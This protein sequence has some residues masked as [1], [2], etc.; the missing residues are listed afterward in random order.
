MRT[1]YDTRKNE[2]QE[3]RLSLEDTIRA[4]DSA[5]LLSTENIEKTQSEITT[6]TTHIQELQSTS[7]E[8]R[9]KIRANRVVILKYL[10]NIYSE[11]SLI[12]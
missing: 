10:S 2:V 1:A 8:Y 11:S 6:R 4:I 3:K 12:A 5:I 9:K 7:L